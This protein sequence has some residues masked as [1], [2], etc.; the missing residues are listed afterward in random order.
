[1]PAGREN[2]CQKTS[3][4]CMW[5]VYLSHNCLSFKKLNTLYKNWC[6]LQNKDLSYKRNHALIHVPLK[7]PNMSQNIHTRRRR[8][9]IFI[10]QPFQHYNIV[11]IPVPALD[12]V[13]GRNVP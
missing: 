2:N 10:R 7:V 5:T 6:P 1:M 9:S 13:L 12:P 11:L 3:Q 8:N 4:E